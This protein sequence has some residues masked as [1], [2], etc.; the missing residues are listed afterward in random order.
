MKNVV[1]ALALL[2]LASPVIGAEKDIFVPDLSSIPFVVSSSGDT[3]SGYV[4]NWGALGNPKGTLPDAINRAMDRL[5][6]AKCAIHIPVFND[7]QGHVK[8][9]DGLASIACMQPGGTVVVTDVP[10]ALLDSSG[11]LGQVKGDVGE[12]AFFLV[13]SRV[14]IPIESK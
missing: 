12:K 14:Q 11:A 9:S 6:A 1:A 10:G 5:E 3:L 13:Q 4:K 7:N 2:A 8:P